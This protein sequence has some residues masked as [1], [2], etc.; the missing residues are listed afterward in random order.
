MG[1]IVT[2]C[3]LLFG[4]I[5]SVMSI[6]ALE[7]TRNSPIESNAYSQNVLVNLTTDVL[8]KCSYDFWVPY[9]TDSE[10]TSENIGVGLNMWFGT[11]YYP[12]TSI[13]STKHVSIIDMQ[14]YSYLGFECIDEG[15]N[16][17]TLGKIYVNTTKSEEDL[18]NTTNQTDNSTN[19]GI[20]QTS[21]TKSS[22]H[23]SSGN[24]RGTSYTPF[25]YSST[26]NRTPQTEEKSINQI[27]LSNEKENSTMPISLPFMLS[28]FSILALGIIL[29]LLVIRKNKL[30]G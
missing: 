20:N 15:S 17:K 3:I 8:A 23:R 25:V 4:V 21:E 18:I 30:K 11:S 5:L 10:N 24:S 7:I 27:N 28:I 14:R 16:T 13:F 26:G 22:N 1:R 6:S 2:T 12:I 9:G 19:T 29:F